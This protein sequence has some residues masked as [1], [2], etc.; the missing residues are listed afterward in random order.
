VGKL[1]LDWTPQMELEAMTF[2]EPMYSDAQIDQL[3]AYAKRVRELEDVIPVKN[4]KEHAQLNGWAKL[5]LKDLEKEIDHEVE[6]LEEQEEGEDVMITED[7]GWKTKAK[8]KKNK[9]KK[10]AK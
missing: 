7:E 2:Y 6:V 1:Y 4:L 9:K 10:A 5:T 8:K 3:V